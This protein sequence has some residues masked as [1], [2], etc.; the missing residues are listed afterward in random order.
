[1]NVG[2]PAGGDITNPQANGNNDLE[3]DSQ[4]YAYGTTGA[5]AT[6]SIYL[7][8]TSGDAQVVLIQALGTGGGDAT[9]GAARFTV[10]ESPGQGE[11]LCLLASGAVLFLENAPE[12]LVH[13][14]VNTPKGSILL[15]VGDNVNT[16]P[17][18]Q[19]LAG[20]SIDIYGDFART[21]G[22]VID[23]TLP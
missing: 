8:E 14:L 15:R 3:I 17:N 9:G 12:T 13:G 4:A 18:A 23:V 20:K 6:G 5:R 1:G 11:D 16:D 22:A 7:T 21:S 2:S 19:I 10:R